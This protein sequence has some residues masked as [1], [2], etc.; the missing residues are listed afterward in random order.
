VWHAPRKKK[1][2]KKKKSRSGFA[3][4]PIVHKPQEKQTR[5][6]L[7]HFCSKAKQYITKQ[8]SNT[9]SA[10]TTAKP[11]SDKSDESDKPTTHGRVVGM[12]EAAAYG[13]KAL[14][15]HNLNDLLG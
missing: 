7:P 8:A 10:T 13:D 3:I 4:P 14:A 5:T 9:M 15:G 6:T 11:T 2:K 1:K 12:I